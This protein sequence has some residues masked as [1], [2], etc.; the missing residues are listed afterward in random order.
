MKWTERNIAAFLATF[1][2][3]HKCLVIIP[4]CL[5]TG[6]ET[7]VLA[8]T[9]DLRIIDVE[10]KVSRS[11][12]RADAAKMKWFHYWDWKVDGP[13]PPQGTQR[14]LRPR[15]WPEKV[16]KHYY[17]L[18]KAIWTPELLN[19]IQPVSGVLLVSEDTSGRGFYINCVRPA[20]PNS[21]ADRLTP[22]MA[23]DLARLASLRMWKAYAKLDAMRVRRRVVLL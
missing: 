20:K 14:T 7:D 17:C 3:S 21:K 23:V 15:P 1:T 22:A 2:F 5:W 12:L 4:N 9:K 8:V 18:P 13:Y 16:W 10:I 6:N 19:E 11:D